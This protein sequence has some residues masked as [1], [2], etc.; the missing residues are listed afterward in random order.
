MRTSKNKGR[1]TLS[2]RTP[3]AEMLVSNALLY[4]AFRSVEQ[5]RRL[6]F[7]GHQSP[8]FRVFYLGWKIQQMPS[9][10]LLTSSI[11]QSIHT[12]MT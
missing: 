6:G 3:E 7:F 8:H 9:A 5:A 4:G 1:R 12:P 11:Q 10:E 2:L